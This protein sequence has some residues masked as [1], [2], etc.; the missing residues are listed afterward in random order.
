MPR[1]AYRR[2]VLGVKQKRHGEWKA[3]ENRFIV[4]STLK[5]H[6]AGPIREFLMGHSVL[7]PEHPD[8]EILERSR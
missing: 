8:Y 4:I 5:K 2:L 6:Y 3:A 1:R 7:I